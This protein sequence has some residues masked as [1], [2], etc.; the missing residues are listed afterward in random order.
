MVPGNVWQDGV[1]WVRRHGRRHPAGGVVHRGR[2]RAEQQAWASREPWSNFVEAVEIDFVIQYKPV[3]MAG[4][5]SQYAAITKHPELFENVSCLRRTTK[6][7]EDG[8]NW[9]GH[10]PEKVLTFLD[11]Y[12]K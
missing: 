2:G 10:H 1:V 9:F 8:Y 5:V 4:L 3:G 12:M 6:R 7:S 11:K